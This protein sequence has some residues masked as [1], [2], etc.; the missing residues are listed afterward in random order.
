MLIWSFPN[1]LE[2]ISFRLS[3][4][5]KSANICLREIYVFPLSR[6]F[7]PSEILS[8]SL[9]SVVSLL[10]L[11]EIIYFFSIKN[12]STYLATVKINSQKIIIISIYR[13][14]VLGLALHLLYVYICR[15]C[16]MGAKQTKISPS[17]FLFGF[18]KGP[19][20]F[21]IKSFVVHTI[22][23]HFFNWNYQLVFEMT[24]C[25]KTS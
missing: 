18:F 7:N 21:T 15:K 5:S 16:K 10:N 8:K 13:E 17:S 2:E 9:F 4:F 1:L 12:I 20:A 14:P 19:V 23:C 24:K 11:F 25:W 6:K 22:S 3:F